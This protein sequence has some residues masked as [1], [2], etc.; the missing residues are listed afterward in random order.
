MKRLLGLL[1]TVGIGASTIAHAQP[2]LA[3]CGAPHRWQWRLRSPRI[4]R[5]PQ[6]PLTMRATAGDHVLCSC[7]RGCSG[8]D[9][10]R[11]R[12]GGDDFLLC[13]GR[14]K[15]GVLRAGPG[16]DRLLRTD[17]GDELLCPGSGDDGLLCSDHE[18]LCPGGGFGVLC[19]SHKLLR[20]GGRIRLLRSGL[21]ATQVLRAGRAGSE[22]F[23]RV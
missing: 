22:F 3:C 23:P 7:A 19:S 13:S 9:L 14:G 16:D 12:N 6:R 20:P 15:H 11:A 17:S 18:L 5:R 2:T 8:H 10:L 1:L 21:C 4:T